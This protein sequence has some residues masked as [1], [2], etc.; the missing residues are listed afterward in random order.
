MDRRRFLLGAGGAA[1]SGSAV[2]GSGAFT[3]VES[4][5]AVTIQVAEDPNAYL[6]MQGCPDSPNQSYTGIDDQ[7]HLFVDMSP[8]NSTD[9]DGVGINSDSYSYFDNVFEVCN[10]G[11]QDAVLWIQIAVNPDLPP[12]PDEFA[13]DGPRVQFYTDRTNTD[14]LTRISA[15][16]QTTAVENG[17]FITLPVGECVCVGIRTLTMGLSN[18]DQL[19]DGDE[20]T[21]HADADLVPDN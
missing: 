2:L 10:N 17:Y 8:S 19:V 12:L 3:R 9:A 1:I 20:V 15:V 4:Q 16:D 18:G 13:D 11:T 6:G 7:G 21:V 14:E 5:R